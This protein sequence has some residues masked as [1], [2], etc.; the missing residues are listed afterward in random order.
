MMPVGMLAGGVIVSLVTPLAG[1][2]S[3]LRA[4]FLVAAAVHL[5]LF[6]HALPR[7]NSA[8]IAA[9]RTEAPREP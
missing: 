4:P 2:I 3:A 1:R 7:L 5:L 6:L 8:A 9:A